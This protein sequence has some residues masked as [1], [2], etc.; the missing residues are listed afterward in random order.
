MF[1]RLGSWCFRRRKRVVVFWVLAVVVVG[2]ISSAVGRNFGQDFEPPGLREHRVAST[3]SRASSTTRSAPASRARSCSAPSRASTTPRC[4]R[5]MEQLFAMV[6]AI[7]ADPDVDVATDPAFAGLDDDADR[8]ARGR[9][10]LP[11]RGHHGREPLRRPT[12]RQQIASQ[13]PEAGQIAFATLEIPG[14]DWENAGAVG[15]TLEKVLPVGRRPAGRARRRR[16]SASSRSRRPR[17]SASPSPIVILI[18]AFGSVLAMGLPDRR[19]AGRHRR[20]LGHRHAP[21]RTCS[22]MPDFAPFLGVMI[23]LGV[24]IDYALFIVTRYRENLHHGHTVEEATSIAIDTA[25]RAVAFAGITVVDLAPRHAR[26]GR[27]LR[28]RAWPSAPPSS[29][30]I[31]MVASLTLLPALLGFAG[32]PGRGHPLAGPRSPPASSPSASS[33][34]ASRSTPLAVAGVRAR[35]SS[36]L[37][38]RLRRR[39]RCS[40]RCRARPPKPLARDVRLPV[41]PRHPAPP[42]AGR[43][44]R[45]RRPARAGHPGARPPPRLLRRGQLRRGHHHPQAYDLLPTASAPASTARSSS[46]PSSPGGADP[47][48]L[49]RASPRPSRPTPGV[50]FVS[51]AHA[52]RP[53]DAHRR[54]L[55]RHPDAPRPQDEATTELVAPPARRRAR[56]R[57]RRHWARRRRHRPGAP[58]TS[59]SPTTSAR[60]CRTSSSPCWRCRSCC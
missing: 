34:S 20:R 29:S 39:R 32:R 17:R 56:R 43:H 2:G 36:S 47:A 46:R 53:E 60:G 8:G 52:Q 14:D 9:R 57:P 49:A 22:S 35:P 33:A 24:G 16:R 50:A 18:L 19:G 6:Q 21:A 38:G 58:P 51:P 25:G 27:R 23:G 5:A 54:P 7:A 48:V 59:T 30:P 15:R 42:V 55:A 41:E 1:A 10:P 11:V 26:H 31:T 37:A 12:A 45:R 40:G 3:S 13:G 44:R 4:R 28:L